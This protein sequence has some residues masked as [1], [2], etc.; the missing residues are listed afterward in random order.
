MSFEQSLEAL[1][2]LRRFGVKLGLENTR[3]LLNRLGNP[4][5]AFKA[6][7]IA[8][9]NGKGSVSNFLAELLRSEGRRVGLYTSPHLH[10]FTERIRID[11][12]P[13]S[14]T[15]AAELIEEVRTAAADLPITFFE[16]STALAFLAFAHQGVACAVVE[17]GLGGRLDATNVL[18]PTLCCIT[19]I[20]LD[21]QAHLGTDL[22]QIAVEKAGIFKA[23]VPV[24]I[25]RQPAAAMAVLKERAAAHK[26]LTL[27]LDEDFFWEG[28]HADWTYRGPDRVMTHL[29]CVQPGRYQ[30]D[31]FS[32]AL[33]A[34]LLLDESGHELSPQTVLRVGQTVRWPGRLEWWPA[35]KIL[36]DAAHNEA[37]SASLVEYLDQ[38]ALGRVHLLAG[39]SGDRQPGSVLA[40]LASRVARFYA[41]PVPEET[42]VPAA[43]LQRWAEA[44]GLASQS[45][46]SVPSGLEAALAG[47]GQDETLV[48][49]GS[50]FLVAAVRELL[51]RSDLSV[52]C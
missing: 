9:T 19:P 17:T 13:V 25:G 50:L 4:Q 40:P 27:A 46:A 37:G 18:T 39:L 3:E 10:C 26:A 8:G 48:V 2:A 12:E 7:H 31:N 20:S 38:Q 49:C 32:Q 43:E 24:V 33:T 47:R 41:V 23:G 5:N 1:Y 6:V 29:Q 16:A 42:S 21:H 45:Y 52:S 22:A 15:M 30:L 28:D 35:E 36:L 51:G 34:A 44:A 11:G 14:K